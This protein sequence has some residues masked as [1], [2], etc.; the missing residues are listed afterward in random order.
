L[1]SDKEKELE[2]GNMYD[3]EKNKKGGNMYDFYDGNTYEEPTA[4]ERSKNDNPNDVNTYD[5]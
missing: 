3:R 2:S 4:K 1:K 5:R